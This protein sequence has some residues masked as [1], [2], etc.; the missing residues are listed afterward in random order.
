MPPTPTSYLPHDQ[1]PRLIIYAQT[2]HSP[3]GEYHSLL[4]L[5]TSNSGLTHL[6]IAAIHL[7]S[8][9]SALTLNDHPPS[10]PRFSTLWTETQ[11][12]Q[13]AGVKVLGMLGGAA[14]GSYERLSG[15][16]SQFEA[17]YAPLH[18]MILA[19]KL[20]GLDLDVEEETSLSTITRLISRLRTDFGP[21]FIITMAPVATAL[22]PDPRVQ[23]AAPRPTLASSPP[24]PNPL[25]PSLPH[26]SG[27]S[28]AELEASAWG[29]EVAWYNAQFYCGWGD[30]GSTQWYE[31]IVSSGGWDPQRVVLGV[32]TNPANGAG[33]VGVEKLAEVCRALRARYRDGEED[34]FGGVMGW[35]WFN[36]GM[37]TDEDMCHVLDIVPDV[38]VVAAGW[39]SVLGRV[40][41]NRL[42]PVAAQQSKSGAGGGF[43]GYTAEQIRQMV[44]PKQQEQQRNITQTQGGNGQTDTSST[45]TTTD[46]DT[47][48][49]E[50]TVASLVSLGF[51]RRSAIAALDATDG[52]VDLAAGFLFD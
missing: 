10:D 38:D 13:G 36:T 28:Y 43:G 27:F 6:I 34:R 16:T 44:L 14:K 5:L 15:P 37:G 7:N 31:A 23:P 9:P 29:K 32:V 42:P 52:N 49:P 25:H 3:T 19:H 35:E 2:F 17:Y 20:D 26:L 40:L 41:R 51:D 21:S 33:H 12:L 1:G 4:P 11:W 48:W 45:T 46:R 24:G 8:D 47:K 50:E 22:I 30:A 18:A 39:V